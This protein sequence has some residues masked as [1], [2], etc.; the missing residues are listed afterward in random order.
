MTLERRAQVDDNGT[1]RASRAGRRLVARRP[2]KHERSRAERLLGRLLGR[3][4]RTAR[5]L[6]VDCA[7]W[8]ALGVVVRRAARATSA[9]KALAGF[10]AAN[11]AGCAGRI[12][13]PREASVDVA[14]IDAS[15]DGRASLDAREPDSS[16]DDVRLDI[17]RTDVLACADGQA[18][19]GGRC[20]DVASDVANCGACGRVCALP[21]AIA[22]CVAGQCAIALCETGFGDCN[23]RAED[24]CDTF[25][26]SSSHCG[27]CGVACDTARPFCDEAL[28]QC[29]TGCPPGLARCAARCVDTR[30][31]VEH[32]G[33]CQQRCQFANGIASCVGGRCALASCNAGFADCDGNA[34]NGCETP[35]ST[36]SNCARCGDACTGG[37][38]VCDVVRRACDSGCPASTLRCG[39]LCVDIAS[40]VMH[41]GGCDRR[42]AF[43]NASALCTGGRCVMGPCAQG[44]FDCDGLS[45]NGCEVDG[46]SSLVH[47]G[48]CDARCAP[49]NASP[50]CV[51]GQCGYAACASGF[52]DCDRNAS[53]GCEAPL[54]SSVQHCGACGN[55]CRPLNADPACV[56]GVCGYSACATGFGDCDGVRSNGCETSLVVSLS[57]CGRCGAPC[58]LPRALAECSAGTCRLRECIAPYADCDGDLRN[59]CEVDLHADASH[60]GSCG[61]PCAPGQSCMFGVCR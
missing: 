3:R 11:A 16:T 5:L 34:S 2:L 54:S 14:S 35:L 31:D 6:R 58:S 17:A 26:G 27:R 43:A 8:H 44:F 61:S 40:D 50:V 7:L 13:D 25:L 59:G 10:I 46:R 38:P 12:A 55:A 51:G 24:G 52:G 49:S 23:G 36:A 9:S 19:C 60:C 53:N 33:G 48:R 18:S 1:E 45:S 56:G 47:C 4:R 42:C 41:C 29:V 30:S 28:G 32:C 22:R 39:A 20:V 37:T 15:F 21:R 57:H